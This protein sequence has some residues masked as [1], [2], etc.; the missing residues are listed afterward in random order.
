MPCLTELTTNACW[1]LMDLP[2]RL[3]RKVSSSLK[4]LWIYGSTQLVDALKPHPNLREVMIN[5]YECSQLPRWITSPLNQLIY[6]VLAYCEGLPSLPPLGKLPL[7]ETLEIQCLPKLEYVGREF[8]GIATTTTSSCSSGT[9]I[10]D[11][12]F[13]KLKTL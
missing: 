5:Q 3:M 8:L 10:I 13:P 11:S 1:R 2:Q 4:V 9:N 6:V 12:G 7:L